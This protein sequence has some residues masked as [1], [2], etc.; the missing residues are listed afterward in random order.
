[1]LAGDSV[2]RGKPRTSIAHVRGGRRK[3]P[4]NARPR[5]RNRDWKNAERRSIEGNIRTDGQIRTDEKRPRGGRTRANQPHEQ[6]VT[7]KNFG[8]TRT[9]ESKR[10]SVPAVECRAGSMREVFYSR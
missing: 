9:V 8:E 4:E 5:L 3:A 2:N 10:V 6:G 1:M 7:L